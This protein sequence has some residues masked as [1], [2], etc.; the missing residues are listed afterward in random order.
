MG[1]GVGM[2]IGKYWLRRETDGE[3]RVYDRWGREDWRRFR[4]LAGWTV[5]KREGYW[6]VPSWGR[7]LTPEEMERRIQVVAR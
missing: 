6:I 7:A 2:R 5:W 4:S 3:P 1:G